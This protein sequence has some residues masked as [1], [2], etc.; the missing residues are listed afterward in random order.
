M[1]GLK[2]ALSS[3]PTVSLLKNEVVGISY[4]DL[5]C[6]SGLLSSKGEGR[7]LI[8]IMVHT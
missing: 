4:L 6:K 7:R 2:E 3:L 1:S 5:L 8:K